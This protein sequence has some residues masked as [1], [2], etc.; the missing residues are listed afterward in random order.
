MPKKIKIEQEQVPTPIATHKKTSYKT[1]KI[2]AQAEP[3][4]SAEQLSKESI[5][6]NTTIIKAIDEQNKPPQQYQQPQQSESSIYWN[7]II[8]SKHFSFYLLISLLGM[9]L[10]WISLSLLNSYL[11]ALIILV[12]V[13]VIIWISSK[14]QK[15]SFSFTEE[16][17]SLGSQKIPWKNIQYVVF[18]PYYEDYLISLQPKN[19]PFIKMYIP[20]PKEQISEISDFISARITIKDYTTETIIDRLVRYIIF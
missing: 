19:F 20:V 7:Y 17:F 6:D 5:D 10:F 18:L 14:K 16:Y 9:F 12:G 1:T 13:I 4:T 3:M 2:K 15:L 11:L 8:P